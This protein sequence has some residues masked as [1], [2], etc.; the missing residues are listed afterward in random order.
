MNYEPNT[1]EWR[2]G[3]LVIHDADA[4]RPDMLMIV[5][6]LDAYG[7]YQTIYL[8]VNR[9]LHTNIAKGSRGL[10][11]RAKVWTNAGHFLHDPARFGIEVPTREHS[12]KPIDPPLESPNKETE[13]LEELSE[14]LEVPFLSLREEGGK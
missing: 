4:K 12:Q 8:D 5:L 10:E 11:L 2:P 3:D 6:G 7:D 9:A 14:F 1:K 13:Y